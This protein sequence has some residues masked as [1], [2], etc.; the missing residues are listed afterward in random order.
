MKITTL[1]ENRASTTEP[2]LN[3][4]WGL[5]LHIEYNDYSILFDTG[6]S[7]SFANNAKQ[8]SVKI[9]SVQVA[10]ISHHH[11]DHGGGLKRFLE[12]NTNAK[13][14]LADVPNGDCYIKIFG[15]L[16]K[17]IGLNKTVLAD[18]RE[19]FVTVNKPTEILPDV[20]IIPHIL[21]T[22]PMPIG[23]KKLCLFKNRKV[24]LDDFAHEIVMAINDS[25]KL[26]I[27]TGCSHN[28]ILNMVDAVSKRFVGVPIKAVIGGFHLV[29]SPPFNFMA[30][31][32]N[33]VEN[34]G[35]S[36]LNYP[37]ETTYTGHCTGKKAYGIL[38]SVMGDKI[39]DMRTGSC[40][41][42]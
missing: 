42:I 23:N 17:Y 24:I 11:F 5:S 34:L 28:G 30:E 16:K 40:F 25:G 22:R 15:P 3:S 29:S 18:Y 6:A 19:R 37:I 35:K 32:R 21:G 36:V 27:F 9:D 20:F 10:V 39:K 1:I 14:Y 26:V 13:V 7:D 38:K 2:N 12:L 8:L 31:T 41:E 33:E 4:E